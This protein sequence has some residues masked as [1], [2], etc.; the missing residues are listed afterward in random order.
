LVS[1]EALLAVLMDY[2]VTHISLYIGCAENL[3][4]KMLQRYAEVG[5]VE[6]PVPPYRGFH[7]RPAT[8]ISK[9]VLHYGSHVRMQMDEEVYDAGS[10]LE[11]FRANEKIN[12]QKRRR[13]AAE[14]VRLKVVPEWA[15]GKDVKAVVREAVLTLVEQSKLILYEQPLQLPD[16]PARKQG[17]TLEKVIDE[18]AQLL[19]LGKVDVDTELTAT[20]IG[21]KR[22]LADI[23]LLAE[24]GYG[25]DSFGN[26]IQ[27]PDKLAYLR[28]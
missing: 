5:Q 20:F 21:D 28:R 24:S 8:L 23:R 11:L 2:S 22:V 15:T 14:I 16:G 27:L 13:L 9:L 7:V 19:A 6:V 25:E 10:A 12:A 18:V 4:H 1:P 26:N 3:C 17:T